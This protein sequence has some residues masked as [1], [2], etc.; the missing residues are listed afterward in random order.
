MLAARGRSA[1]S[2]PLT[3]RLYSYRP[4]D[5]SL[6]GGFPGIDHHHAKRRMT[7]NEAVRVGN[8]RQRRDVI[9]GIAYS[10]IQTG[11][12]ACTLIRGKFI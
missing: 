3:I 8:K 11:I 5:D 1:N 4:Q 6:P 10:T 7:Y 9:A 2:S 12:T